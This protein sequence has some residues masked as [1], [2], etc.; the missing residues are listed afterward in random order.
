VEQA[1]AQDGM[2]CATRMVGR[3]GAAQHDVQGLGLGEGRMRRRPGRRGGAVSLVADERA[4]CWPAT[5]VPALTTEWKQYNFTLKTGAIQADGGEPDREQSATAGTLWL[6][7]LSVFPPTYKNRVNGN[8]VDLMEKLA[9]MHPAVS[10]LSRA[11]TIW[12]ATTSPSASTGRR[13]LGRWWTGRRIP[14]RGD[15][16]RPTGWGCWSFWSG[17]R[18]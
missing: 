17:A 14:A 10:A 8:R 12:R 7:Q 2:G 5:K 9:A 1:D 4:R 16:T 15:T 3:Y 13:R 11:G 18:T 6:Q